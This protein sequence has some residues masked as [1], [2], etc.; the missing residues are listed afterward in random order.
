[1][2]LIYAIICSS[3]SKF[4]N[5]E[6]GRTTSNIDEGSDL[7]DSSNESNGLINRTN[8]ITNID[9]VTAIFANNHDLINYEK[10]DDNDVTMETEHITKKVF[11]LFNKTLNYSRINSF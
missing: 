8:T 5:N 10:G 2:Q 9:F 7:V 3:L 1:M 11:F 6:D 4:E